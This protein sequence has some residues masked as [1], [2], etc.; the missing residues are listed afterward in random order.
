M[1]KASNLVGGPLSSD[2]GLSCTKSVNSIWSSLG[3]TRQCWCSGW[4]PIDLG[5]RRETRAP[6][7]NNKSIDMRQMNRRVCVC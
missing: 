7:H 4:D 6:A 2:I 1:C 3:F 5:S